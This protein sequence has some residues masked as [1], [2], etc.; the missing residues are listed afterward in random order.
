MP[1]FLEPILYRTCQI[2]NTVDTTNISG[3]LSDFCFY[4]PNI[5]ST[6]KSKY[7]LLCKIQLLNIRSP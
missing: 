2:K 1:V 3:Q 6:L 4:T 5:L 7:I